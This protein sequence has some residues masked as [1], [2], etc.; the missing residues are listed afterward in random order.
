MPSHEECMQLALQQA[1][2]A[3]TTGEIP[4][5]AVVLLDGEVVGVGHNQTISSNDPTAHAEVV[6]L[7]AAANKL[8]NYRLDKCTV[9]VTLEPCAMCMGAMLHSRV[10]QVY[11]GAYDPKTG[12]CGSVLNLPGEPRINHHCKVTG[13]IL[14]SVCS[15][16]LSDYF[17]R[18]RAKKHQRHVPMREDAL[19]LPLGTLTNY[20]AGVESHTIDDIKAANGLRVQV[21]HSPLPPSTPK[22]LVLCLHG[23][24]S[25]SC[26]FRNFLVSDLPDTT[27]VWALD[28]LGHGGSDKTK[29]GYEFNLENQ[30]NVLDEFLTLLPESTVHVVGQDTGSELAVHL[31]SSNPNRIASLTLLNPVGMDSKQSAIKGQSIRSRQQYIAALHHQCLNNSAAVEALS[32]PYPDAGHMVGM[33]RQLNTPEMLT[34]ASSVTVS[35][36]CARRSVVYVSDGSF[37]EYQQFQAK[38]GLTF[39]R[40]KHHSL[41]TFPSLQSP[42]LCKRILHQIY[43]Y[44]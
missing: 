1:C 2:I 29:K 6:A 31:A 44:G 10:A 39:R 22:N 25:W 4:V 42:D 14:D 35:D 11:F 37:S 27:V 20:M 16:H 26:I 5:G 13:G 28:C 30:L 23:S 8:G 34:D 18:L 32:A 36:D 17:V 3:E 41:C 40:E 33:L 19:R 12:A 43:S 38:F 15:R 24:T 7:R 9:Y 21:W